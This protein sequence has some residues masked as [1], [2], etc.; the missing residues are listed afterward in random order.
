MAVYCWRL[1][2]RIVRSSRFP[3]PGMRVIRDTVVLH[4]Q[5]AW[6][7]GRALQALAVILVLTV[8]GFSM[9]LWRLVALLESSTA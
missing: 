7:R 3:P 4:G 9:V 1:G 8:V 6:R 5:Q 2:A